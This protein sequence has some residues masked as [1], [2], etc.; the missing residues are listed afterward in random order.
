MSSTL[1]RSSLLRTNGTSE[2]ISSPKFFYDAQ[3]ATLFTAICELDEYY[4]TRT[5]AALFDRY[6]ERIG[7][8]RS[9]LTCPGDG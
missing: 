2:R 6:R 1:A 3:G 5:E 7:N 9:A 4:P 8:G